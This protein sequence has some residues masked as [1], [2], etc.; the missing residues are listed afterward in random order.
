MRKISHINTACIALVIL[1]GYAVC[2]AADVVVLESGESLSGTFSR[3]RENTLV[4]RTSLDGQMMTSMQDVRSL[5]VE[6][7][8][9]I[10]MTDGQ[11]YYGRLGI[12]DK[13]QV[14]HPI[15]G[16]APVTID[17]RA[18]Q[19]TLPIPSSTTPAPEAALPRWELNVT[20]GAQWRS[21]R[22]A[23]V[24][25]SLRFEAMGRDDAWSFEGG[26]WLER[27]DPDDFPAFFRADGTMTLE[28]GERTRPFAS[29]GVE[30]DLDRSLKLRQHLSLG[31][32]QEM[33]KSD[34]QKLDAAV[35]LALEQ[36]RRRAFHGVS[37]EDALRLRLGLRYYHL[38]AGRHS[39]G[40]SLLFY[41]VVAGAG[42]FRAR[43]ETTYTMALTDKLR[44]R[45]DLVLDYEHD[46]GA[47]GVDRWSATIGAGLNMMF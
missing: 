43:S 19:E 40:E 27:S 39:L 1:G 14:V 29:I 15:D 28:S 2:C 41:P 11:V 34:A 3:V 31:L 8:L 36:D 44:L 7:A 33:Y 12:L 30:R 25:P 26:A 24:E 16:G 5:S 32:F 10:A 23:P 22:D 42:D 38:F 4:F 21:D 17:A 9:Y 18:I 47:S 35:G 6:A 45:F 13:A 46:P 20:P 37:R